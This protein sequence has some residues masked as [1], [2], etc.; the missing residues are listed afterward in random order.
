MLGGASAMNIYSTINLPSGFYVYAYI[1]SKDSKTAKA[2]TPY[3]IGKGKGKRASDRHGKVPVPHHSNIVILEENLTEI[4]A[5]AIERR[6]IRWW[7]RKDNNEC[8]GLLLNKTDG[9]DGHFGYVKPDH[10]KDQLREVWLGK[11]HSKH[12]IEKMRKPKTKKH[13]E[14][15]SASKQ[16][17]KNPMFGREPWNKGKSWPTSICP[18]CGKEANRLNMSRWHGDNCRKKT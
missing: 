10:V 8:P 4:G 1:R 7:G 6:M 3:Y 2:G 15:I 17:D 5:V 9:G 12:S 16:G 18:H 13:I 11:K 14:N